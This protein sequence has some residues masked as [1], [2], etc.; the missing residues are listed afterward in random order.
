MICKFCGAEIDKNEKF[1]PYCGKE[2]QN[3]VEISDNMPV[4]NNEKGKK[5]GKGGLI[6]IIA[7]LAVLIVAVGA[8]FALDIFGVIDVGGMLGIEEA[9]GDDAEKDEDKDSED[10]DSED[11]DSEDKDSENGFGEETTYPVKPDDRPSYESGEFFIGATG[12]LTGPAASYGTSVMQGAKLAVDEINAAGGLNGITFWFEMKDDKALAEDAKRGYETLYED[13]MQVSL[14]SVTS[15]SAKSF[16]IRAAFDKVFSLTPSASADNVIEESE[17][18]FRTCFGDYDF[19]IYA[20]QYVASNYDNIGVIY[21]D[22]DAYSE[23]IYEAFAAKM[24]EL[25]VDYTVTYFDFDSNRDFSTQVETLKNCDVIF[26]PIYYMEAGLIAMTCADKGCDAALFGCDGLDGVEAYIDRNVITNEIFYITPF[27]ENSDDPHVASFVSAYK[28]K[29]GC[30]PDQF[31]AGAYDAVYAIYEA[32]RENDIDDADIS[33]EELS[34]ILVRTF[35]SS[36]FE[37]QGVTGDMQWDE[38]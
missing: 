30:L 13:G 36:D 2:I 6:A 38:N 4:V 35:T 29:Y 37:V 14:G 15:A 8:V 1:C 24:E 23:G 16:A 9:D 7:V 19:G 20:A 5:S 22:S 27:Y 17:Y 18:S 25:G 12:P 31:A 34:E 10:K 26:L 21:D 3:S 33:P 32:M 28:E 11:K